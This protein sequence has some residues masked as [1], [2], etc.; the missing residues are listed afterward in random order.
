MRIF[1]T[2]LFILLVIA[3]KMSAQD[4]LK[5][6]LKIFLE[7]AFRN[8]EMESAL[9]EKGFLPLEQ[10]FNKLPWDY[11]GE[12]RVSAIPLSIVDW[13]LIELKNEPQ[14]SSIITRRAAFIKQDGRIVDLDG[15]T[16]PVFNNIANGNYYIVVKHRNHLSVMSSSPITLSAVPD[17]YDFSSDPERIY[18]AKNTIALLDNNLYGMCSGDGDF[19]GIVDTLDYEA[20]ASEIFQTGYLTGDFDMNGV[21]N[22]LDY[23]LVNKNINKTSHV[24]Q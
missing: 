19:N 15:D 12:E 5:L 14:S 23:A 13:V 21:V 8:G 24:P 2:I 7:G 18:G 6:E 17:V 4:S 11:N 10:P 1:Y 22:V 16:D 20:V 9:N 3:S